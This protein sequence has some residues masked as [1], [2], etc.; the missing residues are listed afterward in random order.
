MR[1][2]I[3]ADTEKIDFATGLEKVEV[4]VD[5]AGIEG[6]VV[7]DLANGLSEQKGTDHYFVPATSVQTVEENTSVY[8]EL[9]LYPFFAAAAKII[10]DEKGVLRFR[11]AMT[12]D[13]DQ[14]LIAADLFVFASLLGDEP[15]R[16]R[17]SSSDS[18]YLPRHIVI[19]AEF[20][21]GRLAH[22]EYTFGHSKELIELEWSGKGEIVEF[23]S[24]ETVPIEPNRYTPLPLSYTADSV[25]ARA[26]QLDDAL[27][28]KLNQYRELVKGGREG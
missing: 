28:D 18:R 3:V 7:V 19:L 1:K 8:F 16:F 23:S 6:N 22:L 5:P 12:G 21:E 26:K 13:I 11:R 25:F 2:V 10:T 14:G 17:V 15:G 20:G 9:E 24:R 4:A 27:L